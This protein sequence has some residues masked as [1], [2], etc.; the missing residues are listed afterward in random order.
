MDFQP[1]CN[2]GVISGGLGGIWFV[3]FTRD[4]ESPLSREAVH[5]SLSP[6]TCDCVARMPVRSLMLSVFLPSFCRIYGTVSFV[7]ERR[8]A[9]P[10]GNTMVFGCRGRSASPLSG[11]IPFSGFLGVTHS[12]LFPS[13][14]PGGQTEIRGLWDVCPTFSR[15]VDC[16]SSGVIHFPLLL[17][18][19]HLFVPSPLPQGF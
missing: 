19:S 4:V 14:F 3:W 2:S 5:G 12:V 11:E 6:H 7:L 16:C 13:S 9:F 17:A 18:S 8:Q 15:Q 10:G 1:V